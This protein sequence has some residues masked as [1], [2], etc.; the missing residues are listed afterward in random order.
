MNH[1][2]EGEK[3]RGSCFRYWKRSFEGVGRGL[4]LRIEVFRGGGE[5][6]RSCLLKGR[7][8]EGGGEEGKEGGTVRWGFLSC[9]LASDGFVRMG[10]V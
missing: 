5:R 10:R 9:H 8:G 7:G 4:E 1:G 6:T 2:S 3:K